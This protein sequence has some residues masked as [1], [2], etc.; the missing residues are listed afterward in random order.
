MM[1]KSLLL[2][3]VVVIG[4]LGISSYATSVNV[5]QK[6]YQANYGTLTYVYFETVGGPGSSTPSTNTAQTPSSS[7]GSYTLS[8]GSSAY[9]WSP[10]FPSAIT[11]SGGNWILDLWASGSARGTL[12]IS[13]YITDSAGTV[14]STIASNVAS[15]TIGTTE[16]QVVSSFSGSRSSVSAN[17]YTEVIL[18]APTGGGNPHS[19]TIYW[20]TSQQTNL[21]VP[22]RILTS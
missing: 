4:I 1:F 7:S 10:Q 11:V 22:Y 17:G 15:N 12:R 18:T 6:S 5:V 20:G 14:Q 13:I 21:Q 19:F 8:R 3:F 16:T 9:L 2:V